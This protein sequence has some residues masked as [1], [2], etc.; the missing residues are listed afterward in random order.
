MQQAAEEAAE[1]WPDQGV[2][3]TQ[4]EYIRGFTVRASL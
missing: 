4:R 2:S 3:D 1:K